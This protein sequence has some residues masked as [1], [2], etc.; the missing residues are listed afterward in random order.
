[1]APLQNHA[2][3]LGEEILGQNPQ[4]MFE[5]HSEFVIPQVGAQLS[6]PRVLI[7]PDSRDFGCELTS[8]CRLARGWKPQIST[9]RVDDLPCTIS[10]VRRRALDCDLN[11]TPAIAHRARL[12]DLVLGRRGVPAPELRTG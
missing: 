1:V 8:E 5:T 11:L 2:L 10:N 3:A 7:Q 4:L 9:S 6:R 12:P